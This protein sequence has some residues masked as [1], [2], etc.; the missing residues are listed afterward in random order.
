MKGKFT[1][2]LSLLLMF[3]L[4]LSTF[5]VFI[6]AEEEGSEE[7]E[8]K[9]FVDLMINRNYDEGWQLDNGFQAF[10]F[11]NGQT[12][13]HIDYEEDFE[14]NKNYFTRFEF[15]TRSS[16]IYL[17]QYLSGFTEYSVLQMDLMV[18]GAMSYS[19]HFL[20]SQLSRGIGTQSIFAPS[21]GKWSFFGKEICNISSEWI[22]FT[23]V[24]DWTAGGVQDIDG[25]KVTYGSVTVTATDKNGNILNDGGEPTVIEKAYAPS[26]IRL[27][28]HAATVPGESF[29]LDNFHYYS[30]NTGRVLSRE[31]IDALGYGSKVNKNADIVIDTKGD[32]EVNADAALYT[33]IAY[34][35]G[36]DSCLKGNE[37]KANILTAD[38]GAAYGAPVVIDG[39]VFL[40]IQPLLDHLKYSYYIHSNGAAYDI[41]SG[42]TAT[43][44]YANRTSAIVDGK[45]VYLAASPVYLSKTVDGKEYSYL[46]VC[47]EDIETLFP[48]IYVDYDSMGFFVISTKKGLVSR[49]NLSAMLGMMK[50]FIFD[51]PTG[52][53]IRETVAANTELKHPYLYANQATFDNLKAVYDANEGDAAYDALLQKYLKNAVS[54]TEAWIKIWAKYLR[55]T[56]NGYAEAL[57]AYEADGTGIKIGDNIYLPEL[58]ALPGNVYNPNHIGRRAYNGKLITSGDAPKATNNGYDPVGGRFLYAADML[59]DVQKLAYAYQLTGN[60]NYAKLAYDFL[61][62]VA[63][64]PHWGPG[65]FF[66]NAQVAQNFAVAYDWL[67]NAFV[68]LNEEYSYVGEDGMP[69]SM[70][71]PQVLADA[72]YVK[73]VSDAYEVGVKSSFRE[74]TKQLLSGTTNATIYMNATDNWNTVGNAGATIAAL[75]LLGETDPDK[76][77]LITSLLGASY[78][79]LLANGLDCY[80][81]DGSYM[82]GPS[83]WSHGT[84]QF[85]MMAAAYQS[86][87]GTDFG[88][89]DTWGISTTCY[90]A[91]NIMSSDGDRF[92]YHDDDSAVALDTSFFAFAGYMLNDNTLSAYRY[93]QIKDRD[94]CSF[95]DAF[96]WN[97]EA[98]QSEVK[99]SNAYFMEGIDTFVIRDSWEA[100]ALYVG[101][102]GGSNN[103]SGGHIDAGTFY[104]TNDGV[105]WFADLGTEN[106]N[107]GNYYNNTVRY[108]YYRTN[109]E[110]QNT[111]CI[112]YDQAN[113]KYGQTQNASAKTVAYDSN[114]HGGYHILDMSECYGLDVFSANRGLYVTNDYKTTVIQDNV[115]F[116]KVISLWWFAHT[117]CEIEIDG[118]G[119]VAYLTDILTGKILRCTLV[120]RVSQYKFTKMNTY[121]T[122]LNATIAKGENK[123]ELGRNNYNKLAIECGNLISFNCAVVLE[124]VTSK[125]DPTPCGYTLAEYDQGLFDK[126]T[127]EVTWNPKAPVVTDEVVSNNSLVINISMPQFSASAGRLNES[128][129]AINIMEY[130]DR[131]NFFMND[132]YYN[133]AAVVYAM[134]AFPEIEQNAKYSEYLALKEEYV[135]VQTATNENAA[136]IFAVTNSLIGM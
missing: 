130:E 108:T 52:E 37:I 66:D 50:K 75:A 18:D 60:V 109:A 85:F 133:L 20:Y 30:T 76:A 96:Y 103:V 15:G 89:L 6:S 64:W 104:Y 54:E 82:A 63:D 128:I 65:Y 1:R 35:V 5:T 93:N 68:E 123:N 53:T 21:N 125:N 24:Y 71:D 39:K 100:G 117:A 61:A 120:S 40:P 81:P 58:S 78:N 42:Q 94:T 107:A 32:G 95:L 74:N 88:L 46:A 41:S 87:A 28:V 90:Y 56:D 111:I 17:Q 44:V 84:S 77:A 45:D 99:L 136:N 47:L 26:A 3:T 124:T 49:E 129:S 106:V 115:Q 132:F 14:G 22:T 105:N 135:G 11:N 23:C 110:G 29:C 19:S 80:A 2:F 122:K 72:L 27:G 51:N 7:E 114:E 121:D 55:P 113:V 67:Y 62:G 79:S 25:S 98:Q 33:S 86:A 131:F 112:T 119:R 4:L 134:Q 118:S 126:F 43:S 102:H 92:G 70:Y 36:V 73:G 13:F 38:N 57:A 116:S 31:E 12:N 16:D 91:I 97:R 59:A 83:A 48:G 9:E 8:V 69:V 10:D 127:T 101:L 34:K